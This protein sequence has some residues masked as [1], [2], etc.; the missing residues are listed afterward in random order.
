VAI[1]SSNAVAL[2]S[3]KETVWNEV[4]STPAMRQ[5]RFTGESLVYGKKTVQSETIRSDRMRDELALVSFETKGDFNWELAFLE[6][7]HFIEGALFNS[8]VGM[9]TKTGTTYALTSTAITDSGNGLGNVAVN[10]YLWLSGATNAANNTRYQVT[11]VA[12]GS[13]TLS[14]A[15][16][17]TQSAGPTMTL[18][19]DSCVVTTAASTLTVVVSGSTV[20]FG[21]S[22]GFNPTTATNLQP[23][24]WVKFSGF[25]Q[26]GN[27]GLKRIASIT[28]A[29]IV[30]VSALASE[31][32][33]AA[34]ALNFNGR[35][36]RNGTTEKSYH[37]QKAFTDIN[38]F[39]S[40]RGMTVSDM[41]FDI[42]AS[43]II[44]GTFSFLGGQVARQ[45]T[46][47]AGSVIT[48]TTTNVMTA[49]ANVGSITQA[50]SVFPAGIKSLS[51]TVNNN[52]RP[53]EQI[54][55]TYPVQIGYGFVDVT[56]QI[57]V[58]FQDNT[59]YD[60]LVNNSANEISVPLTD[61]VGNVYVITIPSVIFTEGF[62]SA[63]AGNQDVMISLNWGAIRNTTYNCAIQIDQ[64]P[65]A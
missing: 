58:Y 2:Y 49:S 61:D 4:P 10:S 33:A 29:T 52:L 1:A 48:A 22:T 8:F 24:Q 40:F 3:N 62:P 53:A 64:I 18:N 50:G 17:A 55:Q 6:N 7:E 31:T 59:L 39:F 34:T 20:T 5:S 44:K 56:G 32:V 37:I 54:G 41:K 45:G 19:F 11:A 38:Q 65:V 13:L 36:L 28:T 47:W 15:P 57:D 51:L 63:T 12:A 27:N 42:A 9:Q 14:P 16:A 23:G 25:A 43:Q 35:M 60:Q 26:S 21:G 46:T 30:T